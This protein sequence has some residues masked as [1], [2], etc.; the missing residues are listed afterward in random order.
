MGLANTVGRFST[1]LAPI[2]AE[3]TKP[4][5]IIICI[6]IHAIVI[7]MVSKLEIPEELKG[8][9]NKVPTVVEDEVI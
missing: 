2:I 4:V 1:I 9:K 6:V 8:K 5:P 7:F 3:W